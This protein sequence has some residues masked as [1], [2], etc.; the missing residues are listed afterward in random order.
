MADYFTR[1]KLVSRLADHF[2]LVYLIAAIDK[3]HDQNQVVA[4]FSNCWLVSHL[5]SYKAQTYYS[6]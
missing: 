6:R 5:S 2:Y 4:I 1:Y 3:S